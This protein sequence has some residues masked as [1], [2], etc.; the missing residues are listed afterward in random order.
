MDVKHHALPKAEREMDFFL[1]YFVTKI[2]QLVATLSNQHFDQF[3][4]CKICS[5]SLG[6]SFFLTPNAP[7]M[8][9]GW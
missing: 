1:F 9:L 4:S 3:T 8:S 5:P 2:K 6:S 7:V